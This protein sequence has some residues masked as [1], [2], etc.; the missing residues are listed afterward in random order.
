[1]SWVVTLADGRKLTVVTA[2]LV[3]TTTVTA[4]VTSTIIVPIMKIVDRVIGVVRLDKNNSGVIA[5]TAGEN[6]VVIT[7]QSVPAGA[8]TQVNVAV[9]GH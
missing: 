4:D 7:A 6:K 1:M 5:T 2:A 9:I 8:T 3:N